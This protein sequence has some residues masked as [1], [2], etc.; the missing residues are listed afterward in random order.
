MHWTD[1]AIILNLRKHGENSAVMRAFAY[2]H[3]VYAGVGRGVHSKTMRGIL[4]PGNI[5][6]ATW[7]AR[8]SEHIGSF[9]CELAEANAAYVMH[10]ESKLAA[11][12]AMCAMLDVA[13][14]ERHPYPRLFKLAREFLRRLKEDEQWAE[15]YVQLELA[16]LAESGFGLDLRHCAATGG[17]EDLIYVSPKSGRAV[18]AAAGEPYRDKLLKLP[19]FLHSYSPAD[20]GDI[21]DGLMLTGYFLEHWLLEPHKRRLPAARKRLVD[22]FSLTPA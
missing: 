9:K 6:S 13:L 4:Q 17:T 10:D 18:S 11:L 22:S 12:T 8:L 5:V 1:Q 21:C 7:S 16:I 2:E 20:H 15:Q 3:G 19:E 14:P